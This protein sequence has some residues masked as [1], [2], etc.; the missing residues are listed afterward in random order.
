[1][2]RAVIILLLA[3]TVAVPFL[4]RPKRQAPGR[5]DDTVVIVTP[6]NEAIRHEFELGFEAWYLAKTGRTV[7]VD[8]RVLGGTSEIVRFIQG[9]YVGSFQNEWTGR[10]GRPWSEEIQGA[11][12]DGHLPESASAAARQARS[13]FLASAVSCGIDVFFGGDTYN[14]EK[15]AAAGILVDSGLSR[16]HPEWFTAGVLPATFDG[17]VYRDP[18]DR[19]LGSVTSSY[20]I[21]YNLD[22]IRRLGF[23]RPPAQW[24]DLGDPR[25]YGEIA[26]CDPTKSSSMATAFENVIQQ[27]MH[28]RVAA[29]EPEAAAL[30]A[31]WISGLRLIQRIGANARYFT[32]SSQKPPIDVASG[33]CAAGICIDFYGRQQE[34]AL[35]RRGAAGRMGFVAPA[36]GTA[37]SVD[38]IG[39]LRGA[40][41]QG[42]GRA[43][44]EYVLS[45]DGQKLWNFLPGTPGGPREFA[46]RRLPVR[47]DF[48][49]HEEWKPLRSDLEGDPYAGTEQLVYQPEWTAPRF[50]EMAFIVRVMCADT[51]DELAEAWRAINAAPEPSRSQ[52]LAILQDMSAVTYDRAGGDI[53]RALTSRD[54]VAE[55]RMAREL[56]DGFRHQYARAEAMAKG[57][58]R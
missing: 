1:M 45:L 24:S 16:L 50:E 32:D 55:V 12:L 41:N 47:R 52:A 30:R 5:A 23:D 56:A 57:S 2:R 42:P 10:L 3:A 18:R 58:G 25:Y 51:H 8:W 20:G 7:A 53:T 39:L 15:Q 27:E 36:G 35:R 37:Y 28:R 43:F 17:E 40:K 22:A 9:Q 21:I 26:L 6:N 54:R 34:E 48:Y 4:L 38:P 11:F 49:D 31:G 14:F 44:L 13:A 19:W 33:D 46:L 29:N